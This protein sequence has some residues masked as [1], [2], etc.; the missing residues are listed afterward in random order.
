MSGVFG[1]EV[2]DKTVHFGGIEKVGFICRGFGAAGQSNEDLGIVTGAR[3]NGTYPVVVRK[4]SSA[5]DVITCRTA[6]GIEELDPDKVE[7]GCLNG[8]TELSIWIGALRAGGEKEDLARSVGTDEL[9][10]MLHHGG[11]AGRTTALN[12]KVESVD[13]SVSKRTNGR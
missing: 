3:S 13:H 4:V 11:V 9:S 10:K 12:I 6:W 8:G 7:P 1:F 5:I 2:L